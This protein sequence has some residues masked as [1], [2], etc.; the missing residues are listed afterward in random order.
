MRHW[1]VA[2]AD[3]ALPW[4]RELLGRIRKLA[5]EAKSSSNGSTARNEADLQA[6][7]EELTPHSRS[8][9]RR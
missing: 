1:T 6:A 9:S 5:A 4:V 2:E 3:A 8:R 7:I